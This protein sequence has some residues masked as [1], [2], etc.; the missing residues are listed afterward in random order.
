M[1]KRIAP[2]L[3]RLTVL[4][5]LLCTSCAAPWTNGEYLHRYIVW[6]VQEETHSS[7]S[8]KLFAHHTIEKGA[9]PFHF[10]PAPAPLPSIVEYRDGNTI[11]HIEL[12]S[13]LQNSGTHAF[14]VARDGDLLHEEYFNGYQRDSVCISRSLSKSFTSTLVGIAIGEGFIKSVDDPIVNYLPELKGRGFDPIT[15]RHLLTMQ[16]GIQYRIAPLPWDED[17]LAFFYPNLRELL[18]NDMT[19]AEPPGQSFHYTDYN[20][21][22]LGVILARTTHR[23]PSAYLEEKIWKPLGMEYPATWSIDSEEDGLELMHVALNARAIDF[24]KFGRL[25]LNHGNWNGQQIVPEQWVRDS[26]TNN[27]NEQIPWETYAWWPEHGGYYKYQWWGLSPDFD[28][29][30]FLA[31]GRHGQY[32]FVSPR[33]RLIIVRTGSETGI[34]PE[35]WPLIFQYIADSMSSSGA[36][37]VAMR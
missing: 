7:D 25:Y 26:T 14:I 20:T 1:S 9:T 30:S 27:P 35:L 18:L 10:T 13:L 16:S 31:W 37:P 2:A 24:A 6:G 8:Y 15:I 22:L 3:A 12:T 34:R 28:D 5:S 23:T 4:A 11:K 33:T 19:I 32:I 17:A 29:Y 21:L 36:L